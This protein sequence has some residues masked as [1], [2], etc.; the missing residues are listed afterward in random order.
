[1]SSL[2]EV[3]GSV[4]SNAETNQNRSVNPREDLF[5][6][7]HLEYIFSLFPNLCYSINFFFT[8]KYAWH[9]IL[10]L[11]LAVSG[12]I[13]LDCKPFCW[14]QTRMGLTHVFLSLLVITNHFVN[15]MI[16]AKLTFRNRLT[17]KRKLFFCWMLQRLGSLY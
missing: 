2:C 17:P 3:L 4:S 9:F 8:V 15:L 1:M 5:S 12:D 14:E 10:N 7:L 6:I 13:L 16:S 11:I